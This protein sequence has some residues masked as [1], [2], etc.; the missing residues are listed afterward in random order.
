MKTRIP[1]FLL[2][3]TDD[4]LDFYALPAGSAKWICPLALDASGQTSLSAGNDF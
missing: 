2:I 1:V 4:Y 3:E